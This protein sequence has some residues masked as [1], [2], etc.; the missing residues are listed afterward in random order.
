MAELPVR[1][2]LRMARPRNL[3]PLLAKVVSLNLP[4]SL[5]ARLKQNP[6]MAQ[7]LTLRHERRARRVQ[8]QVQVVERVVER[9]APAVKAASVAVS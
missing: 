7:P 3:Q 5:L 6:P 9:V 8:E 4:T 1:Q 2:R